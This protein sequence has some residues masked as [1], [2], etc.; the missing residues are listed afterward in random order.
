MTST[1]ISRP[2]AEP[3]APPTQAA[4]GAD[5]DGRAPEHEHEHASV[6]NMAGRKVASAVYQ[7]GRAV[8]VF[9]ATAFSVAIL[10]ESDV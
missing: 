5:G 8:G 4:R 9:A 6:V 3:A 2:K 1:L 10:G 7:C